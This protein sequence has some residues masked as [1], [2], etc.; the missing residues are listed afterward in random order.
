MD[1]RLTFDH[2]VIRLGSEEVPGILTRLRVGDRVRY[3]E[4]EDDSL[5]GHTRTPMGWE[6]S[7]VVATLRLTTDDEAT[8]YERLARLNRMFRGYDNGGNPRVLDVSNPHLAARGVSQVVFNQLDSSESNRSDTVT[9]TLKFTEHIPPI[10]EVERR[11]IERGI[12]PGISVTL[13]PGLSPVITA[14]VTIPGGSR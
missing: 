3:D 10:R 8:C 6:D 7:D 2:G 9:V 4:A 14:G 11:G 12:V 13:E 1:G 5:S